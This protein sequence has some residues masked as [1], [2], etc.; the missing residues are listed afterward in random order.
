MD[1]SRADVLDDVLG[2]F[3]PEH[4]SS[5]VFAD[6]LRPVSERNSCFVWFEYVDGVFGMRVHGSARSHVHIMELHPDALVLKQDFHIRNRRGAILSGYAS[7]C[8]QQDE[9][10][11]RG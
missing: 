4:I 6:A 10:K 9:D 8:C 11:E 3:I 1:R 5:L 7:R 2:R